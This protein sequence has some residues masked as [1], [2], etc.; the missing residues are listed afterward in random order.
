MRT[1][2][3]IVAL[4]VIVA[5]SAPA[6]AGEPDYKELFLKAQVTIAELRKQTALQSVIVDRYLVKL[7]DQEAVA[8]AALKAHREAMAA[9]QKVEENK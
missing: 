7:N 1:F 2:I 4:A 8:T 5:F 9:A 3:T 6:V